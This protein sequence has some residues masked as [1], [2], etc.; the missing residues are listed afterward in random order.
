MLSIKAVAPLKNEL[1]REWPR[2]VRMALNGN[3]N[4]NGHVRWGS[5]LV[6]I[7]ALTPLM[8]AAVIG[9]LTL[10][11]NNATNEF[12]G[13]RLADIASQIS[14]I[15]AEVGALHDRLDLVQSQVSIDEDKTHSAIAT[16]QTRQSFN[17]DNI[18]QNGEALSVVRSAISDV[19]ESTARI[20]DQLT[21]VT[22]QVQDL[23]KLKGGR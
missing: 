20:N 17:E 7:Q 1:A 14:S 3:G 19:R 23:A 13:S 2:L 11:H 16:I 4:G 10:G 22:Q 12:N 15:H 6:G 18:K 8:L 9:I 21:S 5:V